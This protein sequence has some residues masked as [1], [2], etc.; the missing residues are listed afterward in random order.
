MLSLSKGRPIARIVGGGLDGELLYVDSGDHKCCNKCSKK[1]SKRKCCGG[2]LLCCD[3][4]DDDI[5]QSMELID[6]KLEPIPNPDQREVPA[7]CGP[8]GS[9]KS[10]YS[11]IYV[12]NFK[13]IF[14]EKEFYL[15]SR[16]DSDPV[17]DRLH[18][19]RIL[20]DDSL[21]KD[22]I[23]ITKELTGGVIIVFDDVTT[24][25]DNKVKKEIEK[26]MMDIMEVGRKLDIYIVVTNHLV[27]P[28]DKNFART[29]MNELTSLTVFPKSGSSQQIRY[30]LKNYFGLN[31]NQINE[32]LELP[33]RW[34]TIFKNYP[35]CVM[36]ELGAYIL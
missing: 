9:G 30:A 3:D 13:N 16:G 35:M 2:C 27:I 22:P 19:N 1:C 10:T 8:S 29:F 33:S 6:G 20:I 5:G 18:P 26:L 36:Y 32:I 4:D 14:P 34:V 11:S 28:S 21:I 23:D 31:N 17:L 12:E 7:I 25:R 15:F 24:I